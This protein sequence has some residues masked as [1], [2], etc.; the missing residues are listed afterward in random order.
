[1]FL[2]TFTKKLSWKRFLFYQDNCQE[3]LVLHIDTKFYQDNKSLWKHREPIG[4]WAQGM[5]L[6][7]YEGW[8]RFTHI[9]SSK[10]AKMHSPDRIKGKFK[11][12]QNTGGLENS[13]FYWSQQSGD[14]SSTPSTFWAE[15]WAHY[16]RGA[17]L[18]TD[19]WDPAIC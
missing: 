18:T 16:I 3:F 5:L 1:L 4:S 17:L 19:W 6:H 14:V 7:W 8:D 15:D 12:E 9:K 2:I 10:K 11:K 13:S